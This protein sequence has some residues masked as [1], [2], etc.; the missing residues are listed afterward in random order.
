[1][2]CPPRFKIQLG[3]SYICL[4]FPVL[5]S[6]LLVT[7]GVYHVGVKWML[8]LK[9][10]TFL[11][12]W[13]FVLLHWSGIWRWLFIVRHWGFWA[14]ILIW[15]R[16]MKDFCGTPGTVLGLVLRMSQFVFAAGSIASMATTISFLY[17]ILLLWNNIFSLIFL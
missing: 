2:L 14:L 9:S 17:K 12:H 15:W 3:I 13:W 10:L 11:V 6:C 4:H 5:S 7:S 16:K 1:M 8:K